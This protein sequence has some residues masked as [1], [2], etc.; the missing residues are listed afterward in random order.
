[1]QQNASAVSEWVLIGGPLR[2]SAQDGPGRKS[3]PH[4]F[5]V[6]QEEFHVE[7][8]DFLENF[9]GG[10]RFKCNI[11]ICCLMC[12]SAIAQVFRTEGSRTAIGT[13]M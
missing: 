8:I 4:S 1:M 5:V 13:T 2:N 9:S 10:A 12:C 3:W 6:Y 11:I 7:S